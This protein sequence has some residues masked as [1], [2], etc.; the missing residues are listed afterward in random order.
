M[1]ENEKAPAI[2]AQ[3]S[4]TVGEVSAKCIAKTPHTISRALSN[5]IVVMFISVIRLDT[6][7]GEDALRL[8]GD[9]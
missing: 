3:R 4:L 7:G 2:Q 5:P 9:L 6:K 8:V 1:L